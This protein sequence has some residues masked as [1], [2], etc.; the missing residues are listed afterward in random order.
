MRTVAGTRNSVANAH[1]Q[2]SIPVI[3]DLMVIDNGQSKKGVINGD[4]DCLYVSAFSMG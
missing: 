4:S 3:N 2:R 1:D